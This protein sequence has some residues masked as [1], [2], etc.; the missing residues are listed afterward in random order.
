LSTRPPGLIP[1]SDVLPL[2]FLNIWYF[3]VL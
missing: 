2:W 3:T 1:Y